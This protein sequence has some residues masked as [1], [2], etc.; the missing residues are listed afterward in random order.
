MNCSSSLRRS[1]RWRVLL[2]DGH[3]FG[4]E[5]ISGE[6]LRDRARAFQVRPV[7]EHV[8]EQRANHAN[9]IDARDA[10]NSAGLRSRGP[11]APSARAARRAAPAGAS[12]AP[13]IS[14]VSIG[15]SIV[16]RDTACLPV[17]SDS[18]RLLIVCTAG[19]RPRAAR[20]RGAAEN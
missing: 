3:L 8:R 10:S 9:G 4:E 19:A 20:R 6:L 15:A 18:M 14:A 7:A 2:L 13:G 17:D 12:R 16:T 5:E 1:E 11:P